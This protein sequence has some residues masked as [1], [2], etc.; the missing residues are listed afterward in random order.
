MDRY[1][2]E[3]PGA[4]MSR[5][6]EDGDWV[7]YED[8]KAALAVTEKAAKTVRF[9]SENRVK[10]LEGERDAFELISLGMQTEIE[11]KDKRIAE[12]EEYKRQYLEAEKELPDGFRYGL[13]SAVFDMGQAIGLLRAELER[14]SVRPEAA[15]RER[16][17]ARAEASALYEQF[18]ADHGSASERGTIER[19]ER[20]RDEVRGGIA[21][22]WKKCSD[23]GRAMV[24]ANHVW[25]CPVCVL[26][27]LKSAETEIARIKTEIDCRIEH[28]A[29][30]NGHLE[31]LRAISAGAAI[32]VTR[33][34]ARISA[35]G[36]AARHT[37]P[38]GRQSASSTR[39]S[40]RS[41]TSSRSASTS[42]RCG[43]SIPA[44]RSVNSS[45]AYTGRALRGSDSA[46]SSMSS[47]CG[48][49]AS[50]IPRME[51]CSSCQRPTAST[52]QRR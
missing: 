51:W 8:A 19:L 32:Q 23:C 45:A 44:G 26:R 47:W 4:G 37:Q 40:M 10:K 21:G 9:V 7:K 14:A 18:L 30:S 5:D 49:R 25:M 46:R 22:P 6:D 38:S 31:G 17:E 24:W 29:E 39:T 27:R 41:G 13:M 12:L 48:H 33:R 16:D 52:S 15:E 28:G 20:E 42:R 43:S 50:T 2:E 11:G 35:S 34:D 1:Y 36:R 3:D